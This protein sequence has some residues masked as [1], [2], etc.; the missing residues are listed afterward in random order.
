MA[1]HRFSGILVGKGRLARGPGVADNRCIWGGVC[2]FFHQRFNSN[3]FTSTWETKIPE[4]RKFRLLTP[5]LLKLITY[6]KRDERGGDLSCLCC[7]LKSYGD[8][9][10]NTHHITSVSTIPMCGH[11]YFK[12]YLNMLEKRFRVIYRL[13]CQEYQTVQY[14]NS[15]TF[16][17]Q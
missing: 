15:I 17:K 14:Q 4:Q 11:K 1:A 5:P 10:K 3:S 16:S 12:K 7:I 8:S 2:F 9:G 6:S 13:F